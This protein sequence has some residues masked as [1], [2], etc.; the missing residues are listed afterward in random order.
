MTVK[1]MG[2]KQHKAMVAKSNL[3]DFYSPTICF[4]LQPRY[5]HDGFNDTKHPVPVTRILGS[6]VQY[7]VHARFPAA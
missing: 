4:L 5:V 7:E 1:G 3:V 2:N 6:F